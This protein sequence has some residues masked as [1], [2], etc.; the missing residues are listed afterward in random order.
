[1]ASPPVAVNS[2]V[3]D[4]EDATVALMVWQDSRGDGLDIWG[5]LVDTTTGKAIQPPPGSGAT[6]DGAFP[7]SQ[8][9]GDQFLPSVGVDPAGGGD[10]LVAWSDGRSLAMGGV[11]E[12]YAARVSQAGTVRDANGILIRTVPGGGRLAPSVAGAPHQWLVAWEDLRMQVGNTA[13]E[14]VWA[15]RVKDDGTVGMEQR[16]AQATDVT[17]NACAPATAWNGSRFFVA[18]EQPCS[19]AYMPPM[20]SNLF[21]AWI[22]ASGALDT[23]TVTIAASTETEVAP[24]LA[25]GP[26]ARLMLVWRAGDTKSSNGKIRGGLLDDGQHQLVAANATDLFTGG[27]KF[28]DSP[29]ITFAAS[30]VAGASR[31]L[32]TWVE[33]GGPAVQLVDETLAPVGPPLELVTSPP[34]LPPYRGDGDLQEFVFLNGADVAGHYRV[35]PAAATAGGASGDALVAYDILESLA[36]H[37]TPRVHYTRLGILPSG[38]SCSGATGCSDGICTGGFCCNTSCDGICQRC[39]VNGCIETPRTDT[40]CGESGGVIACGALSTTC[41]AYSDLPMNLCAAFG[42]CAQSASLAE[43]TQFT[44]A[45]D[46]TACSCTGASGSCRAGVCDCAGLATP[47]MFPT[48]GLPAGCRVATG[49]A[50]SPGSAALLLAIAGGVLLL[51]RRRR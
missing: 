36:G 49:A 28:P 39:G 35:V 13:L 47:D 24:A 33:S 44:N 23:T 2:V 45:A 20:D 22:D 18:W 41:R 7:I 8:A 27:P 38:A 6:S 30:S 11:V 43:C 4:S 29:A 12:I 5:E 40:R 42:Q 15:A 16:V 50:P 9:P 1:V 17:M 10:F 21:G 14:E 26:N 31:G 51:R 37:D 3:M 48:R 25:V 46:G 34:M 32:V 19:Q